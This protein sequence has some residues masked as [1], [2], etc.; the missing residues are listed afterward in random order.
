MLY[1]S[2]LQPRQQSIEFTFEP[3]GFHAK[4]SGKQRVGLDELG[5][6]D[7]PHLKPGGD[8]AMPKNV[9]VRHFLMLEKHSDSPNSHRYKH[10]T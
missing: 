5:R 9:E 7:G 3:V 10:Y 1:P 8:A 2:E 6:F 4:L